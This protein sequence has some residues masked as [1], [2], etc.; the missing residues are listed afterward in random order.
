MTFAQ[1]VVQN[2]APV[3]TTNGMRALAGSGNPLVD[4]F[5][6]IGASRGKNITGQF[7]TA[8]QHDATLALKI[9]LW[10]RDCRS[11]A[12]E[13]ELFK[14]I[15]NHLEIHHPE[16]CKKL[17]NVIPEFG[18]WDDG[19]CLK[20]SEMKEQYFT[21]TKTALDSS[22]RAKRLLTDLDNMSEDE[23]EKILEL[24]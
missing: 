18:R 6:N 13:R 17:I 20:T 19:L 8:Y 11:G 24:L 2:P 15:L 21:M 23:C 10:A 1:A 7:E 3:R 16:A 9:A 4:L 5:Y 12:G 22:Y 14:Q